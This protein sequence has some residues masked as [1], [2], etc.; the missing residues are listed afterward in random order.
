MIKRKIIIFISFCFLGTTSVGAAVVNNPEK[1]PKSVIEYVEQHISDSKYPYNVYY[2]MKWNGHKVYTIITTRK[3][4]HTTGLPYYILYNGKITR[5]PTQEENHMLQADARDYSIFK[6]KKIYKKLDKQL[7]FGSNKILNI[8]DTD[9]SSKEVP[10]SVIRYADKYMMRGTDRE[11]FYLMD[12]N[13]YHIYR[14]Y[15]KRYGLKP[16]RLTIILYDGKTI[17]R[18]TEEEF[19]ELKSPMSNAYFEYLLELGRQEE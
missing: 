7:Y 17:R 3:G 4:I 12:W 5:R 10:T 13:G 15:W 16:H 8:N 6:A 14:V 2:V 1:L 19:K 18:P 9:I 11:I